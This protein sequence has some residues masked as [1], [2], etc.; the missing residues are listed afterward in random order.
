MIPQ[1]RSNVKLFQFTL[2]L[3]ASLTLYKKHT[4]LSHTAQCRGGYYPSGYVEGIL[5]SVNYHFQEI[6]KKIQFTY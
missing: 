1:I 5:Y 2:T 6:F 3:V 4:L